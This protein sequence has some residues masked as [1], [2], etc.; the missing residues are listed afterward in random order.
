ME[1]PTAAAAGPSTLSADP[2]DKPRGRKRNRVQVRRCSSH[3]YTHISSYVIVDS[4]RASIHAC[5]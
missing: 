5:R 3:P 1:D 4:R 2:A